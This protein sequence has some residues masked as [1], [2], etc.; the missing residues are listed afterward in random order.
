MAVT[1]DITQEGVLYT[2]TFKEFPEILL[3]CENFV[4]LLDQIPY[5]LRFACRERFGEEPQ[6]LP[7]YTPRQLQAVTKTWILLFEKPPSLV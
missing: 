3:G 7:D 5:A 2:A 1:P 4:E 6:V